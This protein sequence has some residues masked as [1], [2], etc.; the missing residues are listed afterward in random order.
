MEDTMR[1]LQNMAEAVM[2]REST[3]A[4]NVRY[5]VCL[6]SELRVCA[7]LMGATGAASRTTRL[8]GAERLT[9]LLAYNREI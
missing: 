3:D 6:L 8:E 7:T 5:I 4:A 2:S 9:S 1:K